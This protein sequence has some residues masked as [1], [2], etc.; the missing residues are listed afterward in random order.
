M[1]SGS[2]SSHPP[3]LEHRTFRLDSDNPL[4]DEFRNALLNPPTD[5]FVNHWRDGLGVITQNTES[6]EKRARIEY[7]ANDG[8]HRHD[9]QQTRAALGA[10]FD[11][12]L[13]RVHCQCRDAKISSKDR[14]SCL[15][16]ANM[17]CQL[18][19]CDYCGYYFN[20]VHE[21]LHIVY[22]LKKHAIIRVKPNE[23]LKPEYVDAW[24]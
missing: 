24:T 14:L 19:F 1:H 9:D 8:W 23:S 4:Q 18:S 16:E 3:G 22:G 15:N 10:N 21:L 2:N 13:L 20:K 7:L 6:E 17:D 11:T 12:N 5:D